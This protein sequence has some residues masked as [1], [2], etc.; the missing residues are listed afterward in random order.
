MRKKRQQDRNNIENR[1]GKR[2]MKE[3]NRENKQ[4]EG[5]TNKDKQG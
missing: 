5:K 2:R 1:K 3:N 4:T